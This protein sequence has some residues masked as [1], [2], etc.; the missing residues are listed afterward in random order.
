MSN[1]ET[2]ALRQELE[3]FRA[4]KEK[5]RAV[6]GQIGGKS[7]AHIDKIVNIIF[8]LAI[9]VLFLLDLLRHLSGFPMPLPPLISLELG[10]LLVSI[11]IIWMMHKQAKVEHFQF[12]ILNSIEFR[13]T[14]ISRRIQKI[15]QK[16]EDNG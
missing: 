6:V 5:V 14:D 13:L 4:E 11:K 10:L 2:K 12:W 1:F 3:H 8:I 9:V 7:S 15:E 16:A